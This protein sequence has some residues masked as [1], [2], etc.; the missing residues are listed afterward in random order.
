MAGRGGPRGTAYAVAD[1]AQ[2]LSQSQA[3]RVIGTRAYD[4]A[5]HART[6]H[7]GTTG[8]PEPGWRAGSAGRP[9]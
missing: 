6:N 2:A 1:F 5:W 4:N 8:R 3:R 7:A 9:A